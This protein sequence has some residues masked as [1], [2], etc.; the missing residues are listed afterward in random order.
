MEKRKAYGGLIKQLHDDFDK[1]A[2]NLLRAQGL[3]IAQF[4]I[5][6]ELSLSEE[7]QMSLKAL[8]QRLH[9]AQS[10]TA[11]I[12]ARMERKG[13]VESF[14]DPGDRRIKLVRVT[15]KGEER[16]RYADRDIAHTEEQLL[17]PLT[18]QERNALFQML[19]KLCS[20][21]S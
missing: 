9:V 5:L 6:L 16:L 21:L 2:N 20:S 11:G 7:N 14:G 3:T 8:E 13:L 15:P 1:R 18:L 10:T 4:G 17:S 19:E 12:V